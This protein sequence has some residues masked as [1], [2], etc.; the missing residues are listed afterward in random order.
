MTN[1]TR[2]TFKSLFESELRLLANSTCEQCDAKVRHP[3]LPWLVG[4]QFHSSAERILFVGKPHRGIPGDILDSG[5]ID[6]TNVETSL[7]D[8]SWPFWSY[9]KAIAEN[10]YGR[11]AR[12]FIAITNMI[13]CTN[14][15]DDEDVSSAIDKTSYIMAQSCVL[16]L[17]VIWKEIELLQPTTI[18]FYTYALFRSLLHDIP[19]ALQGTIRDITPQDGAIQ[20]R[21]K[22]L[23]WWER[24]CGTS[25]TDNLRVLVVGHPERM[26]RAEFVESITAWLRRKPRL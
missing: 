7:W 19:V 4:E 20:C 5:L 10:L 14:V 16:K 3:L 12:D 24:S 1:V 8:K 11:N 9:T 22:R 26:A 2:A 25:W 23:G 6:P 21:N 18:V 13:K 15:G 17:G